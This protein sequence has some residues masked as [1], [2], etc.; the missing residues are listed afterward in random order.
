MNEMKNRIM[1]LCLL[2][3]VASGCATSP[4]GTTFDALNASVIP[5][6]DFRSARIRDAVAWLNDQ[7]VAGDN[8]VP[9][10]VLLLRDRHTTD[11]VDLQ[12]T[13][14]TMWQALTAIAK[15][16]DSEIRIEGNIVFLEPIFPRLETFEGKTVTEGDPFK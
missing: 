11:L 8:Q 13:H 2:A 15:L 3:C 16:T 1:V 10:I 14:I 7:M 9:S 6:L 5:E 12:A 4:R